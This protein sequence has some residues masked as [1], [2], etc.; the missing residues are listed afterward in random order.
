MKYT[1]Y[2][3]ELKKIEVQFDKH[4]IRDAL[5]FYL[6]EKFSST[7]PSGSKWEIDWYSDDDG[8]LTIDLSYSK[9]DQLSKEQSTLE[10][11]L[12]EK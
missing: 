1:T 2:Y 8:N 5:Q 6:D 4:D 9:E 12:V 10:Q 7:V 3:S 11:R